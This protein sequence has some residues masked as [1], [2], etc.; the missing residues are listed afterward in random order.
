[1]GPLTKLHAK[2][3]LLIDY[4][5]AG[6]PHP[7]IT[8]V[9]RAAPTE[10]DP[11]ARRPLMQNEP[12]TLEEAADALG[13][14][15]RH[16]RHLFSQTIFRKELAKAATAVRESVQVAALR[17]TIEIMNADGDGSAAWAK[18]NLAAAQSLLN[19]QAAETNKT[20]VN[21]N[22][23]MKLAAGIVVRLPAGLPQTPLERQAIEAQA[24]PE[25]DQDDD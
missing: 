11:E 12:L 3:R 8:R 13:I 24:I 7:F 19:Q 5:T 20:N 14:R 2:H 16:A 4:M 22:V 21:V 6:C 18:V 9:T 1:M 10:F 15:R 23:E 17:K 25:Q